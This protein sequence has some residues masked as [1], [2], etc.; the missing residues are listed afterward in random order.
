MKEFISN[1]ED[2]LLKA[3][4]VI[5]KNQ[6]GITF[7][8]DMNNKLCGVITDGDIRRALLNNYKLDSKIHKILKDDFI[9][10]YE[11]DSFKDRLNVH[12]RT[13]P[14]V[15]RKMEIVD[16]FEYT[17][18]LHFPITEPDLIG[19]EYKYLTDAFLSTFISSGGE[20]V[21]KF[22]SN[23]SKYIS[24]KHGVAT[25]NGT[26]ALHL[27]LLALDIKGGDE[28]IV[29]DLTFAATINAVLHANATPVIVD[30]EKDS[31]CINPDEIKKAITPKTKAI[32]PV[33]IYG[34]PCDMDSIM[35]IAKINNLYVI[36]DCAEAHGAMYKN[37]KIGSFGDISCFSFFGNKILT[38][39]EGGMCLTDSDFLNERMRIL[40]DHGMSKN[41]KYWHDMVGY[42]Y[43]LTNIQAAIGVAQLE[44]IELVL[45]NRKKYELMYRKALKNVS[46][47]KFQED[48]LKH[49]EK[50]VW[51]V[52]VI[53]EGEKE[54]EILVNELKAL[55]LDTRP[56]FHPLSTM[57][58]YKRYIFSNK[59]SLSLS[60]VGFLLPVYANLFRLNNIMKKLTYFNNKKNE[61]NV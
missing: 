42:N 59:N 13:T 20:Y 18:R 47:I 29:P 14:I 48:N 55:G 39:G 49:R 57:E 2:T 24:K 16:Y 17:H 19:N 44:K 50:V 36:E 8:V 45:K 60:G 37:K 10:A 9:F 51:F 6:H 23:F 54:K 3:M 28:V 12:N 33:H 30:I 32:I 22:E 46:G 26:T 25:S 4:E 61:R 40:R 38:T 31:W 35:N 15:N 34:Q 11:G 1:K 58:I 27:A 53:L 43:R 52:P 7:V 41:K 5:N 56:F 21:D